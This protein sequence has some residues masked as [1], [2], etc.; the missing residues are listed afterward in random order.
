MASHATLLVD[1][2][3][4]SYSF[5]RHHVAHTVWYAFVHPDTPGSIIEHRSELLPP[6]TDLV[7][8]SAIRAAATD[9]LALAPS[10]G[11]IHTTR[12]WQRGRLYLFD[13]V[14]DALLPAD[15]DMD[16]TVL[17]PTD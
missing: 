7:D 14:E 5:V 3:Q 12:G 1:N 4:V 15:M 9:A 13:E 2:L 16:E 11:V 17:E 6:P 10:E 8:D